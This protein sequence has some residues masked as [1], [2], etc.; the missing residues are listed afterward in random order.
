MDVGKIGTNKKAPPGTVLE[1]S[2][3]YYSKF[4]TE[5]DTVYDS[6]MRMNMAKYHLDSIGIKN[7]HVTCE[8]DYKDFSYPW[9]KVNVYVMKTKSFFIDMA[10]DNLHPGR[11]AH[12]VAARDIQDFMR[13][14]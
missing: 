1:D 4:H 9:N 10:R 2:L 13:K 11:G 3:L 5:I 7:Y 6:L 12:M 14:N 8:G